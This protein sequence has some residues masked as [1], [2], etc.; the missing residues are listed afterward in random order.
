MPGLVGIIDYNQNPSVND[1]IRR[2]VNVLNHTSPHVEE[3]CKTNNAA[4]AVLRRATDYLV[5]SVVEDKGVIFAFWGHLFDKED[6]IKKAGMEFNPAESISIGHL[7]LNLYKNEGLSGYYKLNGRYVI[8]LWDKNDR[9][10][11]LISDRY[12]F[13]K[14]FYWVSSNR[15]LFASE[16]KAI[17][18]HEDFQKKMDEEAL[19]DFMALGY[20]LG[21]KT[22]FENIKLLPHGS[23]LTFQAEGKLLIERY[24]DYSFRNVDSP[25]K[26]VD[27]YID[28]YYDLLKKAVKR[29]IE[30]ERVIGLPLSG[31][32]DS[33]ALAG[34]LSKLNFEGEVKTFSYGNLD[35]FDVIYGR[36][37][38][39]KLNHEHTYIPIDSTYLR[40]NSES[41]VWLTEGTVNCLNAHMMLTHTVINE[42]KIN[43]IMTGFL[44]DTVGG[45]PIVGTKPFK[46]VIGKDNFLKKIFNNQTDIMSEDDIAV[47][48]K[49][50][51]YNRIKGKTFATFRSDY[52]Q[53]PSE[54]R[55]FKSIYAE[56]IGRQRQYTSFNIYVFEGLTEVLSPFADKEFVNFAL[57]IPDVLAFTRF[58]Q[59]EMIIRYLPKVASVPWNETRLPLNISRIRKSLHWRWESLIR[60]PLIRTTIG[61]RYAKMNDNYLNAHE[62]IRTGSRDFVE[63]SI[64]NNEFLAE[65]FKIDRVNEL[66]DNHMNG[67]AHEPSKI[68]ALLTLALWGKMF[69]ENEKPTFK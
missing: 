1:T 37:I 49:G 60:N 29:Q 55:Y 14:L 32:L 6:L 31:G 66:L 13:C 68:T 41:F 25:L 16:Y 27:E 26:E 19:A 65:Y 23:V 15:I 67:K 18:W 61:R 48:F 8:A 10:L 33:R 64:H 51:I 5:N 36:R 30:G 7:L 62:A 59:R 63:K 39:K 2:M 44:G 38:A 54:N 17:I 43:T 28:R 34:M 40:D 57:Q 20:S 52:L 11:R 21:D 46:E 45:E 56:L 22:F 3:I 9:T 69:V 58:V 24:W 53:A 12:G 4:F 47:Y 42:N 35:C 50:D